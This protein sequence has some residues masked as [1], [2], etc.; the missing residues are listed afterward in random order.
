MHLS[1]S[2]FGVLIIAGGGSNFVLSRARDDLTELDSGCLNVLGNVSR[3]PC[4]VLRISRRVLPQG[5]DMVWFS[6]IL[7]LPNSFAADNLRCLLLFF[8]EGWWQIMVRVWNISLKHRLGLP[9]FR[10]GKEGEL[11]FTKGLW[12]LVAMTDF[13]T[14]GSRGASLSL[15]VDVI[16]KNQEIPCSSHSRHG[17]HIVFREI[18][19][20][21]TW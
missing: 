8:S 14:C 18:F 6:L 17:S 10:P 4:E 20:G 12:P 3:C 16:Y 7:L 11:I 1:K 21:R 9:L 5:S 19:K 15:L 2:Q 13:V